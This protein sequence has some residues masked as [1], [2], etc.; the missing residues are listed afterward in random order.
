ML[1]VGLSNA[2]VATV[3]AGFASVICFRRRHPALMHAAWLLVFIKLLTPPVFFI[4]VPLFGH[5]ADGASPTEELTAPIGERTASTPDADRG[6]LPAEFRAGP[7][8]P[9][10]AAPNSIAPHVHERTVA[11]VEDGQPSARRQPAAVLSETN[12][13]AAEPHRR[14]YSSVRK[15]VAAVWLAGAFIWFALA[16]SGAW[17]IHRLIAFARPASA[18]LREELAQI[19]RQFRLT[20]CPEAY[21]VTGGISPMVWAIGRRPRILL[22]S[23]L[24]KRLDSDERRTVLAHELAHVKRRDRWVR[25]AEFVASGLYWW[26]PVV[27]WAR[28]ELRR[29]EEECCDAWVTSTLPGSSN[30]YAGAILKTLELLNEPPQPRPVLHPLGSGAGTLRFLERRL[31]MIYRRERPLHLGQTG[32]L[33]LIL[34]SAASLPVALGQ[35][36]V[37]APERSQTAEADAAAQSKPP[38]A[39]Q[40]V[41][42]SPDG[43]AAEAFRLLDT[44]DEGL[45]LKWEQLRPDPSHYSLDKNPDAL[46]IITQPGSIYGDEM[47]TGPGVR[48]K[49]IFLIRNPATEGGDFAATV[50]LLDFSPQVPYQQAGLLVY[51]DDDNYL[52]WV[53]E[54]ARY[55]PSFTFLKETNRAAEGDWNGVPNASG[56]DRVWLRVTKRSNLYEYAYSTDGERFTVMGKKAWG[57]GSP[58]WIGI[59]AKNFQATEEIDAVFDS[60]EIRSLT[61]DEAKLPAMAALKELLGMWDAVSAHA[62]GKRMEKTQLTRL[63]F[64]ETEVV[65]TETGG[66]LRIPYHVDVSE[67]RNELVMESNG[68]GRGARVFYRSE[69]DTLWICLPKS[70]ELPKPG[71][72]DTQDGDARLLLQLR[73][74]P[75]T[76]AAGIRRCV[77][78]PQ[79]LFYRTDSNR[80]DKLTLAEFAA[81]WPTSEGKQRAAEV[82]ESL[83]RNQDGQVVFDEYSVKPKLAA[84][85]LFDFDLNGQLSLEEFS[86]GEM[87]YGPAS[88]V[89][90]VFS[91]MDR[92]DDGSLSV[93]E[94]AA[95]TDEAWFIKLDVDGNGIM[96]FSE[97]SVRNALLVSN[98]TVQEVFAAMDRDGDGTL[99][100]EEFSN[101]P[102]EAVFGMLDLD[103][104]KELS[105]QEFTRWKRTPDQI[106]EAKKDFA[107]RDADRSGG[108]SFREYA[109]RPAD[110]PFWKADA[111]GDF[112]LSWKE[113]EGSEFGRTVVDDQLVF[114]TLDR[115]RNGS[116]SL[117]EFRSHTGADLPRSARD[118]GAGPNSRQQ[119]IVVKQVAGKDVV[120]EILAEDTKTLSLY[121]GEKKWSSSPV[122]NGEKVLVTLEVS[123]QIQ[124]EDGSKGHGMIYTR[125]TSGVSAKTFVAVTEN[126]P[127]PYGE[128]TV[129]EVDAII[130]TSDEVTCADIVRRDGS[131]I[132]ISLRLE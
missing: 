131:R 7:L 129:R 2:L 54:Y 53:L 84:H 4:P 18:E 79:Q 58:Q 112:R 50:C 110:D 60:F 36:T 39:G 41:A 68:F 132:P 67:G 85:K 37:A 99:S 46:T 92:D 111:N 44:F 76:V 115:D 88:H 1:E 95:R 113:F 11:G 21:V 5:V 89:K 77:G 15:S 104:S 17:R 87:N 91:A 6:A 22:P 19:A 114:K 127:L 81:D 20:R 97:Y 120:F 30:A 106:A 42:E 31:A 102:V 90:K 65:I 12:P 26:F 107:Q 123:D 64:Q 126:G 56:L 43:A 14:T 13:T 40:A 48:P 73:R 116:I 130:E 33:M 9:D 23:A 49:N 100:V 74:T 29:A 27:W 69:G 121:V 119:A 57:G 71:D 78:S 94:Y 24:L 61:P 96:S 118:T 62:E 93:E 98:G 80:D 122:E 35:A 83:D 105:F 28:V 117:T 63:F 32:Y 34:L 51:D 47:K 75:A 45:A 72:W 103:A 125:S 66:P 59:I 10:S 108:L 38:A 3:L 25:L 128:V 82:F 70:G 16:V 52:K 101:K 124:L 55:G 8:Q 86:V 109:Y